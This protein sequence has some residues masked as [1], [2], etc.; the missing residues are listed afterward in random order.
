MIDG[1]GARL[2]SWASLVSNIAHQLLLQP[3]AT[4][5][6]LLL[7]YLPSFSGTFLFF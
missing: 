2:R 7:S 3:S 5:R 6:Q 1:V 4:S